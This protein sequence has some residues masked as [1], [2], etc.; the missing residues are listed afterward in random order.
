MSNHYTSYSLGQPIY[1]GNAAPY[2][3]T[4]EN[5]HSPQTGGM[6]I[7]QPTIADITGAYSVDLKLLYDKG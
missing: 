2:I 4:L 3:N 7:M 5:N 1:I 6:G